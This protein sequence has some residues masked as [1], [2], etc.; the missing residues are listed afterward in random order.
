LTTTREGPTAQLTPVSADV[1]PPLRGR[2]RFLLGVVTGAVV[3]SVAGLGAATLVKSPQQLAADTHAPKASVLSAV[4]ERRVLTQTVVLRGTVAA[5]QTIDVTA[6]ITQGASKAVVTGLSVKAGQRIR[7]GAVLGEISGRPLI[8]LAGILPAYRDIPP[9][10]KGP[11][12][13]QVQ[14][15]LRGLG[16][17][18]S[19]T[20]GVFGTS[21][22]AAVKKLYTDRGY[23]APPGGTQVAAPSSASGSA[24]KSGKTGSTTKT[25][26][27]TKPPVTV[28]LPA[29]EVVFVAKF[30]ARV[31]QV[32]TQIGAEAKGTIIELG[33]GELVAR[34]T[35]ADADRKLVQV[36][37]PVT[38]LDDGDGMSAS[39]HVKNIGAYSATG[40]TASTDGSQSGGTGTGTAGTD[41]SAQPGYPITVDAASALSERFAGK[42]VRLTIEAASTPGP[43]LVVPQSA[44]YSAADGSTQIIK[45]SAN[46]LQ[47]RITVTTG[48]TGG[49]FLEVRTGQLTAGDRVVIGA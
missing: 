38:I 4:V 12:V 34:G 20:S 5:G 24:G 11:D 16:Y 18:V 21:T 39:G 46:G 31:L 8:A 37:K 29:A 25:K 32:N 2:R 27:T 15:A 47:Q 44:I 19:D 41:Q 33:S 17:A 26:T 9:G 1:R 36:G 10:G 42:D 49:G 43:V 22:Q 48:A 23:D 3:V 45:I 14:A 6:A 35:L 13:K 30:P 28:S 7:A 40:A